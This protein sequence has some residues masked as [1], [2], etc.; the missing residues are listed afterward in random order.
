[1]QQIFDFNS[2]EAI[3]VYEHLLGGQ[4]EVA[5][6][7]NVVRSAQISVRA[8]NVLLNNGK[9]LQRFLLLGKKEIVCFR[10]CG[11][12]TILEILEFQKQL[13]R[14]YGDE[15]PDHREEKATDPTSLL[16]NIAAYNYLF[17]TIT[18][19][20]SE[21]ARKVLVDNEINTLEK[22][23]ALTDSVK[24]RNC[25][26]K[27]IK[28]YEQH[29]NSVLRVLQKIETYK[30]SQNFLSEYIPSLSLVTSFFEDELLEKA[31]FV[32][33][34][35]PFL[36][37]EKWISE[38]SQKNFRKADQAKQAFMLRMGMLGEQPKTLDEIGEC[39]KGIHG[40]ERPRQ[41]IEKM[42]EVCRY[43]INQRRFRPLIQR[44]I[45]IVVSRGGKI[46]KAELVV[47]LLAHGLNGGNFMYAIPLLDLLST[48]EIWQNSKLI[49]REDE[50]IL[51]EESSKDLSMALLAVLESLA[52]QN[53]DEKINQSLWSID[54]ELLKKLATD[55]MNT[56]HPER[57]L[58]SLSDA[59]LQDALSRCPSLVR[60][61]GNRVY[62]FDLW[63]I[64]C[65]KIGNA[66][67]SILELLRNKPKTRLK[68]LFYNTLC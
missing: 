36:S 9:T 37:L 60:H 40:R 43:Q 23:M 46:K 53:A 7:Q 48:F 62:S 27:T 15:M 68:P 57:K 38:I 24:M 63:A 42:E 30:Q 51:I 54:Y 22:F 3:L 6:F 26:K 20:L 44:T 47:L 5:A 4:P 34:E 56:S 55:W 2:H 59:I 39:L 58:T 67:E 28:E 21:R 33:P 11:R 18:Q 64:R 14:E 49:I 66:I 61:E 29:R 16:K 65:D 35:A 19:L 32:D 41:I 25:G 1:M 45:E 12:K 13:R 52:Y 10:N 31:D 8:T 17:E 50:I